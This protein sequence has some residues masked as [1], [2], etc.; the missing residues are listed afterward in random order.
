M[1]RP[2]QKVV[3][4]ARLLHAVL[5]LAHILVQSSDSALGANSPRLSA[6]ITPI[7]GLL[8]T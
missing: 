8:N 7:V 6:K 4:A 1:K 5:I 2:P 3:A